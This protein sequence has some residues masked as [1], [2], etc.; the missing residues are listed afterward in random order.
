MLL[1]ISYAIQTA[2]PITSAVLCSH[3]LLRLTLK[4]CRNRSQGLCGVHFIAKLYCYIACRVLLERLIVN[5]PHPWGLLITF[6]DL[7]K[8]PTY[9]F[10]SHEFVHC[11]PEI[12]K[13]VLLRQLPQQSTFV[14]VDC[15]S[16]WL[17]VVCRSRLVVK[18]LWPG[19]LIN[20]MKLQLLDIIL[21]SQA[22]NS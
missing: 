15:L 7:I 1:P 11:A 2:T 21:N 6:I 17:G 3:C 14:F 18:L 9:K 13:Y 10:W 19:K 16:L 4:L 8:N 5:R 20:N 12:E 22:I